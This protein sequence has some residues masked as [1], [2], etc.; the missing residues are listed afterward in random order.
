MEPQPVAAPQFIWSIALSHVVLGMY[1]YTFDAQTNRY[2]V[3]GMLGSMPAYIRI[4][5]P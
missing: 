3:T 4:A 5:F 1:L 2:P